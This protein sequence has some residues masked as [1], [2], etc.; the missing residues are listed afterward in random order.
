MAEIKLVINNRSYDMACDDGQEDRIRQL[1]SYVDGKITSIAQAGGSR[2]ENHLLML[3]SLVLA[4]EIFDLKES[5]A[6]KGGSASFD[7]TKAK[8]LIDS[9]IERVE[10]L[11]A[12]VDEKN[13]GKAA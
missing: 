8:A 7:T 6:T 4:D 1:A 11:S 12:Q 3:T 10:A 13:G 5:G 9:L 2:N